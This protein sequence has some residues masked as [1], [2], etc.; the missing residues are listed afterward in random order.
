MQ[1]FK[2]ILLVYD[3][4][5]G[6]K[7]TLDFASDLA[8]GNDAA[9]T[10]FDVVKELP[11]DLRKLITAMTPLDLQEAA[12]KE[13]MDELE[14]AVGSIPKDGPQVTTKVL[15]GT[16]FV[17]I[18]GEVLRNKHDLVI[19]TV[20][21]SNRRPAMLFGSTAM[22]LMRKCPCP[23]WAIK[24][25]GP[26]RFDRI[27]AAVNPV[28][29]EDEKNDLNIRIMELAASLAESQ[30]SEFH[31]IHAWRLRHEK[32]LRNRVTMAKEEVQRIL[33]G[34][35]KDHLI[36]LDALIKKYGPKI[37][38]DRIHFVKG[39]AADMIPEAASE[40]KID[41]LVMGTLGRTGIPGMLIGNTAEKVLQE[42][43]CSVLS[44][45]AHGFVTP[46]KLEG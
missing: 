43:D 31:V 26:V 33:D 21:A 5:T 42:V 38:R 19:K 28:S 35:R 3:G 16:P 15:C 22:S 34:V 17:E 27:L 14:Q 25:S 40:H 2:K 44:V 8:K 30:G 1:R 18:I 37:P 20:Q 12:Q 45:K 29:S 6:E 24:P 9:L 10:V 41:L 11:R 13:R 23:V 36:R 32:T 46:I 7:H 4:K 39:E